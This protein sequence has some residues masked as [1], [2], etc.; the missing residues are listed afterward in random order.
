MTDH[1][2]GW[3]G[4]F[5]DSNQPSDLV[6][7][8]HWLWHNIGRFTNIVW[9]I[10]WSNNWHWLTVPSDCWSTGNDLCSDWYVKLHLLTTDTDLLSDWL[11]YWHW[12]TIRLV[13]QLTL[14]DNLIGWS[15]DTDLP[16]TCN[17]LVYLIQLLNLLMGQAMTVMGVT[18][19]LSFLWSDFID[20]IWL[21]KKLSNIHNPMKLAR[22]ATTLSKGKATTKWPWESNG[23]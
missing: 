16:T 6:I 21:Y 10:D 8:E 19:Y 5:I 18:K 12:L 13:G 23:Y 15:T 3:F 17:W 20:T 7:N 1:L 9:Q 4:R 14:A 2:I 22:D 11:V